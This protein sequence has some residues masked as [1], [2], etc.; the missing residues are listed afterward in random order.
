MY[1]REKRWKLKLWLLA[2]LSGIVSFVPGVGVALA[3]W[4]IFSSL[5]AWNPV[6]QGMLSIV[7]GAVAYVGSLYGMLGGGV[8]GRELLDMWIDDEKFFGKDRR[9]MLALDRDALVTRGSSNV[10]ENML[11]KF[12]A[13]GFEKFG[14]GIDEFFK[15]VK[16]DV[17]DKTDGL[18]EK[19]DDIGEK[20]KDGVSDLKEK[21]DEID[22]K[23]K[24][25]VS[26]LKEKVDDIGDK[27][28]DG[29]SDLKE[30]F[31]EID[32]KLKDGV[33]DLKE[34]VDEI[35]DKLKRKFQDKVDDI[36][37]RPRRRRD[38]LCDK[39]R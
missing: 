30:K 34:K 7:V 20:I 17:E 15:N 28:K 21:F 10:V 31:D 29:V 23:L 5:N 11:K 35:D 32:D 16:D 37:K 8:I 14:D 19:F 24:D 39:K 12:F 18:K 25:G 4:W 27:L 2:V 38:G 13:P 22:D 1:Y 6:F 33:S 36:Y 26:D 9:T 3:C